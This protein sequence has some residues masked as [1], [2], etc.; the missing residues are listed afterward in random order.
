LSGDVCSRAEKSLV[1]TC[2]MRH[3]GGRGPPTPHSEARADPF[4]RRQR[5]VA[6][7]QRYVAE[8]A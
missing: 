8:D 4:A 7:R 1:E 2:L 3:L 5:Y 6:R